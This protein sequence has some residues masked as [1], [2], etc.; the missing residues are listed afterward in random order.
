MSIF[1]QH[2]QNCVSAIWNTGTLKLYKQNSI[3]NVKSIKV[4]RRRTHLRD[5]DI[6]HK[7]FNK[8]RSILCERMWSAFYLVWL[9]RSS[10]EELQAGYNKVGMRHLLKERKKE[11]DGM[12]L[13]KA[14][15]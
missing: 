1:Y 7:L 12:I 13:Y 14:R 2:L 11:K 15:K 9:E 5:E 8:G 3:R 10:Q 4:A 6:I